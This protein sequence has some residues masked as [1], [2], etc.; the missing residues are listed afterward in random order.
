MDYSPWNSPGH[1]TGVGSLSVLQGIFPTHELKPRFLRLLH[2]QAGSLPL[3][4]PGKPI[5]P[6]HNFFYSYDLF[7]KFTCE[8]PEA[9]PV[10]LLARGV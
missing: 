9:L 2:W 6:L 1:N 7:H 3:V 4:P 5:A 10:L 8:L